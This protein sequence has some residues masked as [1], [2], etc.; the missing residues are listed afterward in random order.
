MDEKTNNITA[1]NIDYFNTV[2]F[3]S[4]TTWYPFCGGE[5]NEEGTF[6]WFVFLRMVKN[7]Y[8]FD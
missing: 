4:D 1:L 5:E 3:G 7:R 8:G 2:G 6:L